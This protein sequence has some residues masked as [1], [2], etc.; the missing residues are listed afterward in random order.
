MY[1]YQWGSEAGCTSKGPRMNDRGSWTTLTVS[2]GVLVERLHV[3]Q[4]LVRLHLQHTHGVG[5][6]VRQSA[7]AGAGSRAALSRSLT[8]LRRRQARRHVSRWR[9][10]TTRR[11]ALRSH[12]ARKHHPP[13]ALCHCR[14]AMSQPVAA[15]RSDADH[16]APRVTRWAPMSLACVQITI[17]YRITNQATAPA[18]A[19]NL[20]VG[21]SCFYFDNY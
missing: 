7:L 1:V 21:R 14:V 20:S 13:A 4:M 18:P 10:H 8:G 5:R 19:R 16:A 15:P 12:G 3:C 6:W 9:P 2:V 11:G 17:H